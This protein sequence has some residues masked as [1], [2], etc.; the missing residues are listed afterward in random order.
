MNET[1]GTVATDT[2]G[3][4]PGAYS[5][6]YTLGQPS[7][8]P[9]STDKCPLFVPNGYMLANDVDWSYPGE[10]TFLI[11]LKANIA[12]GS[13]QGVFGL[14]HQL[15]PYETEMS[16]LVGSSGLYPFGG[17]TDLIT[18]TGIVQLGGQTGTT[19]MDGNAHLV[20]VGMSPSQRGM[21]VY[22]D[23]V[24]LVII[25]QQYA[26]YCNDQLQPAC[27]FAT[28]G[29]AGAQLGQYYRWNGWLQ[30]F[31]AFHTCLTPAQF[32]TAYTAFSTPGAW[33][34]W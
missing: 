22:Q 3:H 23:N 4:N 29:L 1:S 17:G 26:L 7:I 10:Y 9:G 8:I 24:A 27:G 12:G 15:T 34:P 6:S 20:A 11:A 5:G 31:T 32:A 2:Q 19:V 30:S 18:P 14:S 25:P 21:F 16:G 28:Q 13:E 33:P